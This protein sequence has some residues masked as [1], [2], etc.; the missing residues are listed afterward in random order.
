MSVPRLR[1]AF[2][3]TPPIAGEML[4]L[5]RAG[6][7]CDVRLVLTR[8]DR[9]GGRGRRLA[10]TPV[11]RLAEAWG[12][13]LAQPATAEQ[14]AAEPR[15]AA[16]DLLV[17][18]AYGML[19][20]EAALQAPRLGSI[21]LHLSLLPRWRGAAPVQHA[22]LAGDGETGVSIMYLERGLDTGPILQQRS[23][24]ILPGESAAGLQARLAGLGGDCLLQTL[25]DLAAGRAVADRQDAGLATY[26][27]AIAKQQARIDWRQ[28]ADNIE[29]MVRAFNPAPVAYTE[30]AGL[31]LRVW[32]AEVVPGAGGAQV[33]GTVVAVADDGIAVAAGDGA[34]VR[35]SVV[36]A[37]G[38][39]PLPV[40]DFLRGRPQLR[41]RLRSPGANVPAP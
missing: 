39:R 8:P 34:A 14:F 36:Q 17:V 27:P 2:A 35:L 26:A 7:H 11:K 20:P 19:L 1:L 10:A 13:P 5:L 30:L 37:P 3:G 33:P 23:C 38:G 12:L 15:L 9:R 24:P 28:Q 31:R 4:A 21:N 16:V 25:H 41:A 32:Q 6:K 22:I 18:V 40:A 29:R